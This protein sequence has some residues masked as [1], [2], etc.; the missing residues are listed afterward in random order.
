M[1]FCRKK[2]QKKW[3][4]SLRQ[5]PILLG[6]NFV[7]QIIFSGHELIFWPE[8]F[9]DQIFFLMKFFCWT[10]NIFL[11]P[12]FFGMFTIGN[13]TVDYFTTLV[14]IKALVKWSFVKKKRKKI[15]PPKILGSKSLVK[16]WSLVTEMLLICTNVARTYVA[17]TNVIVTVAICKRWSKEAKFCQNRGSNSWDIPDM[18][19]YHL[20]ECCLDKCHRDSW[21]LF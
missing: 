13:F 16:I 11:D 20:D 21:N 4:Q 17:W 1:N 18:Y 12:T 14:Q 3:S 6:P 19:K 15:K 5:C 9:L 7:D 2:I 8:I 10:K